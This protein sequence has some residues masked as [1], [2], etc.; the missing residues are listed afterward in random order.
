MATLKATRE[1]QTL[2]IELPST[3]RIPEELHDTQYVRYMLAGTLYH[4][5]VFSGQEARIF[6]GDSRRVF[7]ENMARYGF[8]LVP[9]DDE[10]IA[11]ELNATH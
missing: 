3:A 4:R 5:G 7:E 2:L 1:A 9:D 10:A 11:L 8:P 6:T